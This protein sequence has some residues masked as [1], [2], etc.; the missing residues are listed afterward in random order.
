MRP[1]V[2]EMV[3][4]AGSVALLVVVILLISTDTKTAIAL[5]VFCVAGYGLV[6][7]ARTTRLPGLDRVDAPSWV[8]PAL[9]VVIAVAAIAAIADQLDEAVWL[10]GA[11]LSGYAGFRAGRVL[12]GAFYGAVVGLVGALFFIGLVGGGL[13]LIGLLNIG[14]ARR[15]LY[16]VLFAPHI[17]GVFTLLWSAFIVV[18]GA[19]TGL[20]SG[21]VGGAIARVF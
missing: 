9:G 4:T 16:Q 11:V 7:A 10:A 2:R 13:L 20:V 3:T 17:V 8:R 1:S 12:K 15:L 19:G 6:A 21:G 14:G 5:G 18:L